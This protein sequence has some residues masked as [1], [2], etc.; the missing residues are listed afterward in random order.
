MQH[1]GPIIGKRSDGHHVKCSSCC[2]D[3]Q[4]CNINVPCHT[5]SGGGASTGKMVK[6]NKFIRLS[7]N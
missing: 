7:Q 5:A 6:I 4:L 1:S 2:N 3:T